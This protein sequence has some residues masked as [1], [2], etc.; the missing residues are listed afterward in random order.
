[1]T[2]FLE[3]ILVPINREGYKFIALFAFTTISSG[4]FSDLALFIGIILTAWCVY[5]FRDP[6]RVPPTEDDLIISPA[7]GVVQSIVNNATPPAELEVVGEFTRVS[8]FMSPF[9]VH[10]NRAPITGSIVKIAYKAGKFLNASLDKASEDNERNSLIFRSQ[11]KGTEIPIVQI[12]GLIARRIVCWK[13]ENSSLAMGEKFGMIRFGSRV[14][15]YLPMGIEPKVRV[16]QTMIA[17]ESIIAS[18]DK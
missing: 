14:D 6:E 16:G 2:N 11:T 1:M 18:L 3:P 9:N 15:V 12:A 8:I 13:S 10:V 5:F 4:I 7:D 17:G